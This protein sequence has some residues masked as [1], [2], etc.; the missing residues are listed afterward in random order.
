MLFYVVR[1]KE[2][3]KV[4]G[5][6]KDKKTAIWCAAEHGDCTKTEIL[7]KVFQKG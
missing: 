6:F 5:M 2:N 4:V 7:I 3:G 1:M